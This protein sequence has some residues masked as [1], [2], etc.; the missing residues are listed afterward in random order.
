MKDEIKKFKE[1]KK[2]KA[3]L[4]F[5]FYFFFFLFLIIY[6]RKNNITPNSNQ[7]ANKTYDINYLMNNDFSY[8][9]II[10]D[11]DKEIEYTG[12]KNNIDYNDYEN[13]Y[14]LDIFNINQIIKNS[15]YIETKE[16][17]L[18]Y[19]TS[20]F[21]LG[22]LMGKESLEGTSKIDVY[23][24]EKGNLTKIIMDLSTFM[25]KDK[26]VITLNYEVGENNEQNNIS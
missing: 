8:H 26:Y 7:E 17:V 4:F 19:E 21:L 25:N 13:K 23:V 16:N 20:N 11:N 1:N 12:T 6:I 2:L 9:I 15:K 24:D 18:S 5:G 14:I 3:S 22:A 10:N